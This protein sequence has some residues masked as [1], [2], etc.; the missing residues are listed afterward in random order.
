MSLDVKEF[1][2]LAAR[3]PY[4]MQP[5]IGGAS[6]TT[7]GTTTYTVAGPGVTYVELF[8]N[9]A[10]HTFTVSDSAVTQTFAQ[11]ERHIY[12]LRKGAVITVT[13]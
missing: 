4:P 6:L 1:S 2:N 10:T 7:A 12:G 13:A 5:P 8:A 3:S 9:G 11:G